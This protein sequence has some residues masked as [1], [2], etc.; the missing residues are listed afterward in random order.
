VRYA[1]VRVRSELSET[2]T[3]STRARSCNVA[4]TKL[5]RDRPGRETTYRKRRVIGMVKEARLG[6]T[7]AAMAR[8]PPNASYAGAI[9]AAGRAARRGERGSALRGDAGRQEEVRRRLDPAGEHVLRLEKWLRRQTARPARRVKVTAER[10][11][12]LLKPCLDDWYEAKGAA[13]A[14]RPLRC[15]PARTR[16]QR[17][18]GSDQGPSGPL[19]RCPI[20]MR[21][22]P[23][24]GARPFPTRPQGRVR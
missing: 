3:G 22:E 21:D 8:G 23:R 20:Q 19:R 1:Y 15:R 12:G 7:L 24:R 17:S 18:D 13:A 6:E 14:E 16:A 10:P 5:A 11:L 4:H 2:A 9:C